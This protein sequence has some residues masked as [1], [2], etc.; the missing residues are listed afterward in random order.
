MRRLKDLL[1]PEQREWIRATARG[2]PFRFEAGR[3]DVRIGDIVSPMRYD[4]L[5]RARHFDWHSQNRELV[6]AD[7]EEYQSLARREP[8][9]VWFA[10]VM[11][12]AWLPAAV[13]DEELFEHHWR[14][15]LRASAALY[16]SFEAKGFD[17]AYPV[18]L[19]AGLRVRPAVTG[20]VTGRHLYAGDG[21]HRLALLIAAGNE[22][23][24]PGQYRVKRYL[25]LVPA[26]TT[27]L[28]LRETGAG[29]SAYRSFLEFGYP[30]ARLN[31]AGNTLL[32]DCPDPEMKAEI[33]AVI[34]VDSPSLAK[35]AT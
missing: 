22:A 30:R 10:R 33:S 13:G 19:Y 1:S 17:Q 5:L 6:D 26:D 35:A 32:V 20:K 29:V 8:Y 25:S 31:P 28:L 15:R 14:R 11:V 18:E 9:F 2:N 12:P 24:A 27:G 4:I 23:L 16:D 21:N 34:G 3:S 7:F